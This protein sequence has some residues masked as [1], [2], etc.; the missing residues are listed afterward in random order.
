MKYILL[1]LLFL[2]C[3]KAEKTPECSEK[4]VTDVRVVY[5]DKSLIGKCVSVDAFYEYSDSV[6]RY[7]KI[8][9]I[10]LNGFVVKDLNIKEDTEGNDILVLDSEESNLHK[11][12]S[13]TN[14]FDCT[15][16]NLKKVLKE[17]K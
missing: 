12:E 14:T 4:N 6:K 11:N 13:I 2:G 15:L 1:C 7:Y 9:R 3:S 17:G 5:V 10:D 8:I 16:K